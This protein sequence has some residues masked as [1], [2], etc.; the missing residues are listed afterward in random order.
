M[1]EDVDGDGL[2][3]PV[4]EWRKPNVGAE[5]P[6]SIPQTN[7]DFDDGTLGVQ[8]QWHANPKDAWYSL[9]ANPGHLRLHAVRNLTQNGNL[10]FVPNLPAPEVSR[11]GLHRDHADP[12][13]ARAAERVLGPRRDG[14]QMVLRRPYEHSRR[15]PSGHVHGDLR[16]E[17]GR[18]GGDRIDRT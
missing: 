16:Q 4:A 17:Q 13:P 1:G 9:S 18:D 10:W 7:D 6:V 14:P 2:G 12:L 15:Y 8:W 11:A 5:H 3:E